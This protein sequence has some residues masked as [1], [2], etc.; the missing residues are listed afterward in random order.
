[1]SSEAEIIVLSMQHSCFRCTVVSLAT[2]K[3]VYIESGTSSLI[4][5]LAL[6]V[7]EHAQRYSWSLEASQLSKVGPSVFPVF[8]VLDPADYKKHGTW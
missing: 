6:L 8:L 7:T 2:S 1:M 5:S 3:R 4:S